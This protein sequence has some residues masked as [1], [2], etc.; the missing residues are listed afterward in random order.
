VLCH[1]RAHDT[2]RISY[3][4]FGPAALALSSHECEAGAYHGATEALFFERGTAN[5]EEDVAT[6]C[7]NAPAFFFHLQCIHGVGHGLMAWTSYELFD[8]LELCDELQ[9]DRD[10]RACYSGVFMENV[11]GGKRTLTTRATRWRRGT[12]GRATSTTAP[13]C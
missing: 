2:G 6:V 9:T 13:G 10:Q 4:L 8:A 5:L 3:E 7:G 11:V 1:Q 12:L